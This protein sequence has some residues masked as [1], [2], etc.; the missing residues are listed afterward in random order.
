VSG[1][2]GEDRQVSTPA[3]LKK[4]L[5]AERRGDAFLVYRD[6]EGRQAIVPL[7]GRQMTVGR[8]E[9]NDIPLG[10]DRQVSRLHAQIERIKGD[11]CLVD[12]GLSRN[13]SF[14]NAERIAG[15]RRLADGDRLC[16]GATVMVYRSPAAAGADSTVGVKTGAPSVP[17]SET[18]RK[19]LIALTRP[20]AES[21][22]ATPA[23]NQEIAEEVFLSV[24]AVKAH[25]RVLFEQFGLSDLP[26]NQKRATLAATALLNGVVAPHE[27]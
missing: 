22:F 15:K 23:T 10:W 1:D 2:G 5:E 9:D 3:E 17:L 25:L 4:R 24:N 21:A 7:A 18:R 11:W 8:R 14:V 20:V 13:G 6:G 27:F 19:V 16:F 26:Q 12:D